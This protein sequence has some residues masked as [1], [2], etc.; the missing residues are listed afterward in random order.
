LRFFFQQLLQ[1]GDGFFIVTPIIV[2]NSGIVVEIARAFS[3]E[4][5]FC[6]FGQFLGF[7]WLFKLQIQADELC[8]I[9]QAVGFERNGFL[10]RASA[11]SAFLA[12][13]N[14]LNRA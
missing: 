5:A 8:A 2:D 9:L 7:G 14:E 1:Q 3:A 13:Y 6:F 12:R 11:S 4:N 10:L